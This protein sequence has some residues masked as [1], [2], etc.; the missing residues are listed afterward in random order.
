[1]L[2]T[3]ETDSE[4]LHNFELSLGYGQFRSQDFLLQGF[5]TV[6]L[7]SNLESGFD[8]DA[9]DIEGQLLAIYRFNAG[10]Q[11]IGGVR[12]SDDFED[13][14]VFPII[15]FR[16]LSR[17]G[18]THISLTAPL[19]AKVSY[20]LRPNLS[21]YLGAW[22]TGEEYDVELP[23]DKK[24]DVHAH[25]RRAGL[26]ATL[27]INHRINISAEVGYT[28]G[29]ELIFKDD[30]TRQFKDGELDDTYYFSARVGFNL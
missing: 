28:L 10:A 3:T 22:L 11:L 19:E 13:I 20:N 16:L 7:N 23:N 9:M 6:D 21:L 5:A 1:M 29:S 8:T 27:W 15:G 18:H 12:Y 30:D 25:D 14:S 2:G 4:T 26:G 17:D 24:F